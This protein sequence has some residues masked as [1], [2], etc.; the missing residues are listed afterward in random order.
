MKRKT[1][2]IAM[3]LICIATIFCLVG[4]NQEEEVPV[5]PTTEEVV[6]EEITIKDSE[7]KDVIDI[8]SLTK[9]EFVA[10]TW[11]QVRDFTEIYLPN[12]RTIYGISEERVMEQTD[13]ENLKEIMFWQL[14]GQT[15]SEYTRVG[16]VYS[17]IEIEEETF[18]ADWIYVTPTREYLDSLTKED[19]GVYIDNFYAYHEIIIVQPD[20]ETGEEIPFDFSEFVNSLTDEEF[21]EVKEKFLEAMK[22]ILDFQEQNNSEE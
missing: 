9:D 7:E 6:E 3:L 14:F 2:Y 16:N 18:G 11:E 21:K 4:C 17:D 12:Y 15:Y 22:E 13:W 8:T 19:F 10:L 1:K 20:P 5:E